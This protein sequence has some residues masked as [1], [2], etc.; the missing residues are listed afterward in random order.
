MR[1]ILIVLINNMEHQ[2]HRYIVKITH[3]QNKKCW[4]Q[5]AKRGSSH[6]SD[7][8]LVQGVALST[9]CS[10]VGTWLRRNNGT[11]ILPA[12]FVW[13]RGR[14]WDNRS[15]FR[16]V[17]HPIFTNYLVRAAPFYFLFSIF[18]IVNFMLLK[19][20]KRKKGKVKHTQKNKK[21]Q[22]K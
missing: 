9:I 4:M 2:S 19:H 20:R 18:P 1:S 13:G 11:P 6:Y 21:K 12:N 16:L 15:S 7:D 14:G 8:S 3:I 17:Y 10:F 22:T 5:Q